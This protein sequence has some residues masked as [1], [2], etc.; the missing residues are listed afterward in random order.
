[1]T[2]VLVRI[3]CYLSTFLAGALVGMYLLPIITAPEAPSQ[4]ALANHAQQ[5]LYSGEF[6]DDLTGSDALHYGKGIVRLSNK[7]ISF[8]GELSPGPDYQLYLADRF[9]D[10]EADFVAYKGTFTRIASVNTFD[11][12]IVTIPQ[13]VNIADYNTVV[14]WC[15]SFEQFISAAQYQ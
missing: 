5:A 2:R 12:F 4:L 14:I 9:V 11:G 10:N 1:M 3:I 13:G 6:K 7:T 15:E 8:D